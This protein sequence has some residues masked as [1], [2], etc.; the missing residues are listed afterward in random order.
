M[1]ENLAMQNNEDFQETWELYDDEDITEAFPNGAPFDLTGYTITGK[2]KFGTA[3]VLSL[4]STSDN[5]A[6]GIHIESPATLGWFTITILESELDSGVTSASV[7]NAQ[8]VTNFSY[9][10]RMTD[11]DGIKTIIVAGLLI[12]TPGVV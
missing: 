7:G 9:D 5:T 2:I 8:G 6:S 12:Y 10:I 11:P 1:A 3:T 4:P